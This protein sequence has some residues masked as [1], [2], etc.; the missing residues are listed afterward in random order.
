MKEACTEYFPQRGWLD[1][2]RKH[3]KTTDIQFLNTEHVKVLFNNL[4]F[5]S[6]CVEG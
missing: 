1:L 6:N 2:G 4:P 3:A 5:F